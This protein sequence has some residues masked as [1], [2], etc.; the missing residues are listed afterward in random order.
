MT[1]HRS[2]RHIKDR[3]KHQIMTEE[4]NKQRMHDLLVEIETL[5]KDNFPIKQQCTE[6]I[7]CLERA[8]EMFV[9]R[10]TNEG[11]SLQD[12]RLGEIEIKQYSAMKQMAIKGGLPHEQYNLR[13]REVRVRLFGEQMVKDNFD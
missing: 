12:Y 4:E 11:Y 8:H 7:A 10:A 2:L 6:A 1:S 13:I 9:Q 5:E 3:P